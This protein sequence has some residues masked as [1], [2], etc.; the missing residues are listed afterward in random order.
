MNPK[1]VTSESK[2]RDLLWLVAAIPLLLIVLFAVQGAVEVRL[3]PEAT[4]E[5]LVDGKPVLMA[6]PGIYR[7]GLMLIGPHDVT[8]RIAGQPTL[9]NKA[10][11]WLSQRVVVHARTGSPAVS[12]PVATPR[13]TTA[14][15]SEDSDPIPSSPEKPS[16]AEVPAVVEQHAERRSDDAGSPAEQAPSPASGEGTVTEE[17]AVG[18]T[19]PQEVRLDRSSQEVVVSARNSYPVFSNPLHAGVTYDLE[20]SGTY[21]AWGHTPH[22]VDAVACFASPKCT[23]ARRTKLAQGLKVDG[24]GLIDI[25]GGTLSYRDDHVYRVVITGAGQPLQFY[26]NDARTSAGDNVGELT[27]RISRQP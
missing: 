22:A 10:Y 3:E 1:A 27:V 2:P 24:R 16:A 8:I 7:S 26:I 6:T 19:A 17:K 13:T 25:S 18:S 4:A 23:P 21:D 20:V 12:V 5:V 11:V 9:H 14:N 15:P